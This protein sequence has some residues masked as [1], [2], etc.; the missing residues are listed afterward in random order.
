LGR[1]PEAIRPRSGQI[2]QYYDAAWA[3]LGLKN[4][5]I[6]V[7]EAT[8]ATLTFGSVELDLGLSSDVGTDPNEATG[9]DLG[10]F[11]D[12]RQIK[13]NVAPLDKLKAERDFYADMLNY[14]DLWIGWKLGSVAGN[15]WS[16][17]ARHCVQTKDDSNEDRL[18]DKAYPLELVVP[19]STNLEIRS[20]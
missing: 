11:T 3:A 2:C 18:S 16:F 14:T 15:R 13:I 10:R 5:N 12:I 17:V 19:I 20:Y 9:F 6:I 4:G 7:C 1:G 8:V